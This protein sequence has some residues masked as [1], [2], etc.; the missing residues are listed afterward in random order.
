[1][2]FTLLLLPC[3]NSLESVLTYLCCVFY[4]GSTPAMP[5]ASCQL[6]AAPYTALDYLVQ[7]TATLLLAHSIINLLYKLFY[8]TL[9]ATWEPQRTLQ[10]P[11]C[12]WLAGFIAN[13]MD[14]ISFYC[15]LLTAAV[16]PFAVVITLRLLLYSSQFGSTLQYLHY[17]FYVLSVA[18]QV[19]LLPAL[20]AALQW[21]LQLTGA[22]LMARFIVNWLYTVSYRVL[23]ANWELQ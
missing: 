5:A 19:W 14:F 12:M 17:M 1:M 7:L 4:S 9:W 21:S 13:F 2:V 22:L 11:R 3:S 8:S 18:A 15:T 23:Y 6:A 10:L 20:S 16:P